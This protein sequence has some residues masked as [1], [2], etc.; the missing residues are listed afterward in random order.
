MTG[1][2]ESQKLIH[3]ISNWVDLSEKDK[4][5]IVSKLSIENYDKGDVLIHQGQVCS[6]LKFV[7]SGIYRVFQLQDG[8]DITNYFNYD[9][10]NPFVGSFVSLLRKQASD[11][12]IECIKPGTLIS[13]SYKEWSSLYRISQSLNTFGRL[14]AEYNYV[15]ALERITSLQNQSAT[16]RYE[17]FMKLYPGLLNLIP[18]HYIAS[19][20]G[21][22]PESL[23][24]IRKLS[25]KK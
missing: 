12:V 13:I 15:L 4:E 25:S 7:I 11:E 3:F 20:L 5:L 2:E 22:T 17:I 21:I 10:R 8:K 16:E 1:T 19:Y 23:S 24:R 18:H 9:L 6:S 14:M